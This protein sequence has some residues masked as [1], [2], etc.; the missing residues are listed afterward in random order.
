MQVTITLTDREI[1]FLEEM[2]AVDKQ[3]EQN[4]NTIEDA[5]HECIEMSMFDENE[6]KAAEEGM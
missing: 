1:A 2:I 4:I 5:I 3:F 6:R